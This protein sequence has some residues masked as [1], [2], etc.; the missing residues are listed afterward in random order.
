MVITPWQRLEDLLLFV[1]MAVC[2]FGHFLMG[3]ERVYLHVVFVDDEKML[4]LKQVY[5]FTNGVG[6]CNVM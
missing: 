3:R 1:S 5:V 2:C 6:A 4:I